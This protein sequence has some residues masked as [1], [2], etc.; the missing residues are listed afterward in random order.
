M[1]WVSHIVETPTQQT[2]T[3]NE[4]DYSQVFGGINFM[5]RHCSGGQLSFQIYAWTF[6]PSKHALNLLMSCWVETWVTAFYVWEKTGASTMMAP[7]LKCQRHFFDG[8]MTQMQREDPQSLMLRNSNRP[9]PHESCLAF[10][11]TSAIVHSFQPT[12]LMPSNTHFKSAFRQL[13]IQGRPTQR[14]HIG[15]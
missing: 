2:A 10:S 1:K 12:A 15:L 4:M 11:A 9:M 7:W 8:E 6:L 3:V 13:L 14:V 5:L